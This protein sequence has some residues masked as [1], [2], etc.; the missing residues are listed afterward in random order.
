MYKLRGFSFY[1][2][3]N[4]AYTHLSSGLSRP[5]LFLYTHISLQSDFSLYCWIHLT[6]KSC[7]LI[8]LLQSRICKSITEQ[9]KHFMNDLLIVLN[10]LKYK[11][12]C[13]YFYININNII[14]LYIMYHSVLHV[15]YFYFANLLGMKSF[16]KLQNKI[17]L[18]T[19]IYSMK[20]ERKFDNYNKNLK[21][22]K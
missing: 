3:G 14:K 22:F 7:Y 2:S 20:C 18:V 1:C 15:L 21:K 16:F 12:P 5:M 8:K 17:I 10:L 4:N 13:F 9:N 6:E 11:R 19:Q